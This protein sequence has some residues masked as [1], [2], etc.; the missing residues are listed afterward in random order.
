MKN[1]YALF[2]QTENIDDVT[3]WGTSPVVGDLI[4]LCFPPLFELGPASISLIE[5][6]WV[7]D[8]AITSTSGTVSDASGYKYAIFDATPWDYMIL[9]INKDTST[10]TCT[11]LCH[12]SG[13]SI[14]ARISSTIP[15]TY[16][17]LVTAYAV[18][19]VDPDNNLD[20]AAV[21]VRSDIDLPVLGINI[22]T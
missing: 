8:K 14:T 10:A 20:Y 19:K 22:E 4:G 15:N 1:Q 16:D 17:A 11:G 9:P 13:T 2:R 6:E 12:G 3:V 5:P 7:Y 21:T 18:F